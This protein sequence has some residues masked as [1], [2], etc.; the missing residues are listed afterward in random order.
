[1]S[2]IK[3]LQEIKRYQ[4]S[5]LNHITNMK[6]SLYLT[7]VYALSIARCATISPQTPNK[8]E[9]QKIEQLEKERSAIY[10]QINAAIEDTIK[11]LEK[12]ND[13]DAR[14]G[15]NY[16]RDLLKQIT[17]FNG[18]ELVDAADLAS[19]ATEDTSDLQELADLKTED[20]EDLNSQNSTTVQAKSGRR[21]GRYKNT[22]YEH[23]KKNI[24]SFGRFQGMFGG[25]AGGVIVS[26][27]KQERMKN[28]IEVQ[29]KLDAWM[30]AREK[31]RE[32]IRKYKA[33]LAAT[34]R[35]QI[36][37]ENCPDFGEARARKGKGRGGG[38]AKW[39]CCRK[40]CKKSYMG[41]L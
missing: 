20:H 39:P 4:H 5:T 41:C 26:K 31:E 28:L 30:A 22:G 40:C 15:I 13:S 32:R 9:Q 38:D 18:T 7:L 25:G 6:T 8:D 1:M 17:E 27:K 35:V 14:D 24:L 23:I 3:F 19:N 29:A 33:G 34:Q 12:S 16:M 37:T 10:T 2:F 36:I 11:T 21:K